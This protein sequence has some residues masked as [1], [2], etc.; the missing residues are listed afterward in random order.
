MFDFSLTGK[1]NGNIA[2]YRAIMADT[3]TNFCVLQA[4]ANAVGAKGIAQKGERRDP[5]NSDGFAA[6]QGESLMY[7]GNGA[8]DVAAQLGGTVT[9][10]ALLTSDANGLLVVAT[11][12][13]HIIAQAKQAGILNDIIDVDV[14]I[15]GV[16]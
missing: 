3:T 14:M 10:G 5:T 1:A 6:I 7:Y 16:A 9:A 4:T 13:Q 8:K 11:T 12:G 15:G 2:P